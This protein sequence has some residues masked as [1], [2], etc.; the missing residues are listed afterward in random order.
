MRLHAPHFTGKQERTAGTT[1]DDK[2]WPQLPPPAPLSSPPPPRSRDDGP[3]PPQ[4]GIVAKGD[5]HQRKRDTYRP[6][7]CTIHHKPLA[8]CWLPKSLGY[9]LTCIGAHGVDDACVRL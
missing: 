3:L 2:T 1:C 4:G 9:M 6:I 5:G 7:R 8:C